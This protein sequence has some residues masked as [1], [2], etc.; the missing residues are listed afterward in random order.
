MINH[1]YPLS[2]QLSLS[3]C[4]ST[5]VCFQL[6]SL[7]T[8][9]ISS[10]K[11]NTMTGTSISHQIV[12]ECDHKNSAAAGLFFHIEGHFRK[13]ILPCDGFLENHLIIAIKILKKQHF[14]VT[15]PDDKLWQNKQTLVLHLSDCL[16]KTI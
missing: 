1:N 14:C 13:I 16:L 15:V 4:F 11:Q 9:L 8:D 7:N 2:L 3:V 6:K 5:S 10:A 12:I